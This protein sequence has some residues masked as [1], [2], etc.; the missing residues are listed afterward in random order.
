MPTMLWRSEDAPHVTILGSIHVLDGPLPGWALEAAAAADRGVYEV[1]VPQGFR[2]PEMPSG[3][4]IF[5]LS[6]RLG[7]EVSREA[8]RLGLK[9]RDI[10]HLHPYVATIVLSG[11]SLP[12]GVSAS[13]GVE[14]ALPR[15]TDPDYLE[16]VADQVAAISTAPMPGT[17]VGTRPL[18]KRTQGVRPSNEG[19]D[20]RVAQRRSPRR[21]GVSGD[22]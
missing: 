16:T 20:R 6:P 4:T 9:E 22:G 11:N 1:E 18:P 3:R 15:R 13:L 5:S 17:A 8:R 19:S 21:M 14:K 12:S 10:D 7:R 2:F